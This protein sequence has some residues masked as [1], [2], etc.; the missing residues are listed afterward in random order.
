TKKQIEEKYFKRGFDEVFEE[1]KQFSSIVEIE[2]A[3]LNPKQ[4][5]AMVFKWYFN[6]S[7][8]L[9]L[10]GGEESKVDYQIHC[11]PA[12]GAFNQWV[13]GTDLEDWR[14]RHVDVI[15]KIL[16]KETATLLN[17]RIKL[18]YIHSSN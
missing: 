6:Y 1:V 11:G 12:L 16:M 5:M 2:K 14:N 15:G 7:S 3:E 13:K 17:Q 10:N 9:A 18:L 4:K 8:R